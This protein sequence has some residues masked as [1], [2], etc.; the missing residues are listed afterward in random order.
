MVKNQVNQVESGEESWRQFDVFND[1][2]LGV[3]F[4]FDGVRSGENSCSRV[5]GTDDTGFGDGD[6]LLLHGFVKDVSGVI[7]HFIEFIDAADTTVRKN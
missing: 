2:F 3:V 7:V 1:W 6:S 5:Q 4:A